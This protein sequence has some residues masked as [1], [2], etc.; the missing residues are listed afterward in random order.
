MFIT[1]IGHS[2]L[3]IE[4]GGARVLVDPGMF[5]RGFEELS[6][7]DAVLITHA[8]LD[9]YDAERLPLVLEANDG[10]QLIAEPE[11]SAELKRI[12]LDVTPL[13]PGESAAVGEL[14][15][16]AA[17]GVHAL[18]HEDL[19]R[20]GNVGLLFAAEGEPTFFHPGDSYAAIPAGVDVLGV[21]LSAPW[22]ALKETIA[23]VRAVAPKIAIPIHDGTLSAPGR[24]V[25]L[26]HLDSLSPE[27]TELRDLAGA[28]PTALAPVS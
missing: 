7:L 14:T 21:P 20:I 3:L 18:I 12:G 11:V 17:G 15:V 5:T 25:Y 9:H 10:A 27:S 19:P 16:T 8:H 1:H 13:H 4:T 26:R 6:G 2:C 23:F 28:G 24:A 22:T